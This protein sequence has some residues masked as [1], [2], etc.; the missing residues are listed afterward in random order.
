MDDAHQELG[1]SSEPVC[2]YVSR[3]V[4]AVKLVERLHRINYRLIA[5]FE[6]F[7][8]QTLKVTPDCYPLYSVLLKTQKPKTLGWRGTNT[9]A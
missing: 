3:P 2:N 9:Q 5:L 1:I 4:Q 6:L 7:A 8:G